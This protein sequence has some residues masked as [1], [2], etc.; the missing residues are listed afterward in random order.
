MNNKIGKASCQVSRQ[1]DAGLQNDGNPE[2]NQMLGH[3]RNIAIDKVNIEYRTC[4]GTRVN[5][6]QSF[7]HAGSGSSDKATGIFD[8]KR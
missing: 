3:W 8:R 2:A 7:L 1:A 4:H 6:C 5:Q